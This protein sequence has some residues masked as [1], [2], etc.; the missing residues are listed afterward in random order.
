MLVQM[1]VD[2]LTFFVTPGSAFLKR[3]SAPGEFSVASSLC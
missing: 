1:H 2:N 3:N